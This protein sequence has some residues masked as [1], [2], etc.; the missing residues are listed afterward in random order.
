MSHV[1]DTTPLTASALQVS[2]LA[3]VLAKA[4][5]RHV[6]EA[7]LERDLGAGAPRNEDGTVN[8]VHYAAWLTREANRGRD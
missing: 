6:G 2:A 3:A 4:G 7:A 1:F 8:L 5:A